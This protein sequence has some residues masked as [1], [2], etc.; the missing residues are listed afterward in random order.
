MKIEEMTLIKKRQ[1]LY[2]QNMRNRD[3]YRR[4]DMNQEEREAI[5]KEYAKQRSR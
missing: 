1:K 3:Q 5:S 2:L 4:N